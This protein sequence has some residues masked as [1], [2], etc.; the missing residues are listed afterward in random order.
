MAEEIVNIP[1]PVGAP[2]AEFAMQ[3]FGKSP[4]EIRELWAAQNPPTPEPTP[5]PAPEP[6]PAVTPVSDVTPIAEPEPTPTPE[7]TPSIVDW[8]EFGVKD[9]NELKERLGKLSEYEPIV[10]KYNE[11]APQLSVLEQ[12]KNPFANDTIAQL[13][14]FVSKT[15]INNLSL[16]SEILN[17]SSEDLA[18]DP[19]KAVAIKEILNDPSLA[20]MSMDK[21]RMYVANKNGVDLNEYG[22]EGYE[23]PVTL[24]VDGRRAIQQIEEKKKEFANINNYFVDLQKNTE[25]QQR[26]L[27]TRREKWDVAT[28]QIVQSIKGLTVSVPSPID[29]LDDVSVTVTVS[30]D[31]V[32]KAFDV[33]KGYFAN[34]EEPNAEGFKKAQ[35][36]VL[37]NLRLAKQQEIIREAIRASEGKM[38]EMIVKE[39]HNLAP[40]TPEPTPTPQAEQVKSPAQLELERR[41]GIK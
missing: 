6:T 35:E 23:L 19:L 14:N 24:E 20:S 18:K 31:E 1:T 39:S 21:V 15:G 2:S 36:V 22:N 25:E 8:S 11:V 40:I 7:P 16:A 33:V 37:A 34:G 38:R 30:T 9:A 3:N 12:V 17:S 26:L 28:P 10:N 32:Q 4:E 5:T 27:N 13:N 29:G 41:L